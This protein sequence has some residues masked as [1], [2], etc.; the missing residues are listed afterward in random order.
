MS[1]VDSASQK[2]QIH[3]GRNHATGDSSSSTRKT[4]VAIR[5]SGL[6]K[7]FTSGDS[8]NEIAA[9]CGLDL[10]V[11]TGQHVAVLGDSGSGKT[12]LLGCLSGRLAPTHGNIEVAQ[13]VS[14][15]HQDLRLVKQRTALDNI[16]DG[17]LCRLPLHRTCF[18]FPREERKRAFSLLQRVGLGHRAAWPIAKL[19]GGEQQRVAIA[20]SLMQDPQILLA[21]EPVASLDTGNA[22]DIMGLLGDLRRERNLTLVSVLH[23]SD[24]AQTYADR[25][26]ALRQGCIV[27]DDDASMPAIAALDPS[28]EHG[29]TTT[30]SR[31]AVA[32]SMATRRRHH[33]VIVAIGVAVFALALLSLDISPSAFDGMGRNVSRFLAD[34]VPSSA[35]EVDAIPWSDLSIA[36]FETLGMSLVG[37]MLGVLVA[38][39]LA[40]LGA[41]NVGPPLIRPAVRFILNVIRTV[42]SLI[43]ALLFVAAVGLG[44]FAGVL[45]L[46]AYSVGYLTK[47][48]YE[49][50]EAVDQGPPGALREI[51]ASGLQTFLLSVWPASKPAILS[52][53]LFMFE[54]NV[55]A[56]S[57]LGLVGAGGIGYWFSLFFKWRNFPAAGACLLLLLAVVLVLD[58]ISTRV[59]ARMVAQAI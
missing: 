50:F 12:T 56:A 42:P 22:H 30:P 36:L 44:P 45:A 29:P 8:N 35:A 59:R 10:E 5:I 9:L 31:P 26:V 37:T 58:A 6:C 17:A 47:F 18:G 52:S 51:G 55:R 21:D 4:E 7:T 11:P 54:Y 15:V 57:V 3:P 32:A 39:P 27:Y 20:R 2:I 16:L 48:F 53:C 13:R 49:A 38:W 33:G 40:A 46:T 28:S 23:D 25:I 41:K 43:W 1:A 14:T 19:S 34:L 24:L